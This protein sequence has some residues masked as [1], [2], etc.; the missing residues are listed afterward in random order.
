MK[1]TIFKGTINGKEFTTVQDYNQEIMKL[2][3]EGKPFNANS[4]TQVVEVVDECENNRDRKGG[5]SGECEGKCE[6]NCE[7]PVILLPGFADPSKSYMDIERD[8]TEWEQVEAYAKS[9]VDEMCLCKLNKYAEVIEAIID[10]LSSDME[11]NENTA[12]SLD[13][14]I[15]ALNEQIAKLTFEV[16]KIQEK[17]D[18][19]ENAGVN[20][21]N[22]GEFYQNI[23]DYIINK[24]D[25]LDPEVSD[26]SSGQNTHEEQI[27]TKVTET[28]SQKVVDPANVLNKIFESNDISKIF[29]NK[30][31][32]NSFVKWLD[33]M[34][35]ILK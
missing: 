32:I 18:V 15:E 9:Q 4:N 35:K 3:A 22:H 7:I 14:T 33:D 2:Q 5:Y 17:K 31:I 6:C 24:L 30:N 12:K 27:E 8:I 19:I 1:K 16:D 20:I 23:L 13:S 26:Q 11:L 28:E 29:N 21:G 34:N 10:K 25:E